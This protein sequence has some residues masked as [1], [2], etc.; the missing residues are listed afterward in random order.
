MVDQLPVISD[1]S[2]QAVFNADL[3][4]TYLCVDSVFNGQ[5]GHGT[6]YV[7]QPITIFIIAI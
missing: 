1:A 4:E 2:C 3:G 7:S 6:C 5:P